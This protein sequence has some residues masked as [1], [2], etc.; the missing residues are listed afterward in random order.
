MNDAAGTIAPQKKPYSAPMITIRPLGV[1]AQFVWK[2]DL[3]DEGPRGNGLRT[4]TPVRTL[5]IDGFREETRD[6]VRVLTAMGWASRTIPERGVASVEK[7][8]ER[9]VIATHDGTSILL[10]DVRGAGLSPVLPVTRI[11][12]DGGARATLILVLSDSIH[13]EGSAVRQ[14]HTRWHIRGPIT[15][16]DLGALI[17]S[18]VQIP[19]LSRARA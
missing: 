12:F 13:E 14:P 3:E 8:Q 7:L 9:A 15:P 11:E 10:A 18:M 16:E 17:R 5:I 2:T 1:L 19:G 4:E 6:V